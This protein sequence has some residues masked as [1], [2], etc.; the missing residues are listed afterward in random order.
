MTEF[1]IYPSN[2]KRH[3]KLK[4]NKQTKVTEQNLPMLALKLY[5][6]A[7]ASIWKTLNRALKKP[8]RSRNILKVSV[9]CYES[10]GPTVISYLSKNESCVLYLSYPGQPRSFQALLV[11]F[12]DGGPQIS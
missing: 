10:R 7:F 12:Y 1:E 4:T 2:L 5:F 9:V 6:L 11:S 3:K 8:N